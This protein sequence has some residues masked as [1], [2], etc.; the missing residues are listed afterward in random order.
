M[1][2][3]RT[4]VGLMAGFLILLS[5]AAHSLVGWKVQR[6]GLE[7]ARAPADLI[8]GLGFGW[9]FA[10][11][12]MLTFGVI[13]LLTFV[14]VLRRQPVS[15]RPVVAIGVAY[16]VYGVWSLTASGLDPFFLVFLVPGLLLL[17]AAQGHP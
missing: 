1:S 5:S 4:V 9:Q 12:A 13:V 17:L 15:L 11:V 16:T 10:G 7:A 8:L 6:A 2:R 14:Q 3:W